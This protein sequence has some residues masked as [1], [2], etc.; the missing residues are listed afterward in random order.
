MS[1]L[2][3]FLEG[4]LSKATTTNH[5]ASTPQQPKYVRELLTDVSVT[6]EALRHEGV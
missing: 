4:K 2:V 6:N 1:P 3:F 5:F